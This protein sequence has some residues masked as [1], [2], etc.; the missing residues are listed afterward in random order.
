MILFINGCAREDSRTI[1]IAKALLSKLGEYKEINL[2][3]ENL[4]PI[5]TKTLIKRDG[6][7][8]NQNFDDDMFRYA[9]DL[10]SADTVVIALPF[11][12]LSFPSVFKIYIEN[13]Y[14]HGLVTKFDSNG[15][16]VGLCKAN[17]VYYVTTSGGPYDKRYSFDYVKDMF[18]NYFGMK[19]CQLIYAEMLDIVGSD[20]DRIVQDVIDNLKI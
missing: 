3:K 2:Y 7:I 17:K 10:K 9:K 13:I 19:E 18:I 20:P 14:V 11:W 6:F 12:D 1:K 8:K 16:P 5:D 4:N 15:R